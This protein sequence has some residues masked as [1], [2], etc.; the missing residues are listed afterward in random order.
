[1]VA[2]K[3][4][5]TLGRTGTY[6]EKPGWDANSPTEITRFLALAWNKPA[7]RLC[8]ATV[9]RQASWKDAGPPLPGGTRTFL[10]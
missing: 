2:A 4:S 3:L 6:D 10:T 5:A 9:N 8:H 7:Q 1:M